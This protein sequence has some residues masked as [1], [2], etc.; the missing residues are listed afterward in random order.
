MFKKLYH[1]VLKLSKSPYA[2]FWLSFVS[3]AEA[4]F[5]PLPPEFLLIPM[6][7]AN[8]KQAY[9]FAFWASVWSVIGGV[10]G[11]YIGYALLTQ[12]GQPIIQAYHA[13]A[14]FVHFQQIYRYWGFLFIALKG[15]TP[16]PY[17]ILALSAGAASYNL[18][19]FIIASILSRGV[20]FY[21]IS[22][23]CYHY[24]E[25]ARAYIEHHF[26]LCGYICLLLIFIVAALVWMWK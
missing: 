23:L 6:A 24:G 19:L 15:L 16:I 13:E 1:A 21:V 11:Y 3:F 2:L 5:L 26:K 18:Y 9:C 7:I 17:N 22:F 12:I 25:Q 8:R 20:R 14:I 10:L 4:V